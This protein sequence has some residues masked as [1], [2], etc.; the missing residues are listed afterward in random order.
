VTAGRAAAALA[1][2]VLAACAL[3]PKSIESPTGETLSGRLAVQVPPEGG[4]DAR[5]MTAAFELL[6]RPDAGQ[7]NLS[8]PLGTV[9]GQARW[10][11]NSVVLVTPHG[12]RAFP[13][14]DALTRELLGESLP[15]AALFDWL[16][17]RPWPGAPSAPTVPPAERGFRQLG[18]TVSLAAFDEG[19]IAARRLQP[20]E[21]TVRVR[22]DRP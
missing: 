17:G 12:Q 5:A 8:T 13:D 2:L 18:W 1:A 16:K 11:P 9:L 20:P 14:L 7:L 21:V 3:P 19:A 4:A 22:L 6:G 10:S 15:V